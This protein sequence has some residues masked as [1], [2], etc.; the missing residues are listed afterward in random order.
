MY[1]RPQ[2][3]QQRNLNI[4]PNYGGN[5]FH[6]NSNEITVQETL[7][8]AAE[9]EN[10]EISKSVS[11]ESSQEPYEEKP[12]S[13]VGVFKKDS[14]FSKIGSEELLLLAIIFLISDSGGNDDIIWLLILL[15]FIK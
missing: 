2:S 9:E 14:F 7:S 13:E 4:P 5:A 1:Y 15:L 11:F 6:E 3:S 8:C 10:V 12:S